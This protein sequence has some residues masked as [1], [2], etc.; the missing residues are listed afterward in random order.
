VQA[1]GL[2]PCVQPTQGSKQWEVLLPRNWGLGTKDNRIKE[3]GQ[4]KRAFIRVPY[5]VL[6][7]LLFAGKGIGIYRVEVDEPGP[8]GTVEFIVY[9]DDN[10]E[11]ERGAVYTLYVSK[12]LQKMNNREASQYGNRRRLQGDQ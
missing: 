9:G 4:M 8:N 7:R 2:D 11:I 3:H 6:S 5:A 1:Q 12:R 10:S